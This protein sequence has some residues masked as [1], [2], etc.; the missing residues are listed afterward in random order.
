MARARTPTRALYD[1]MRLEVGAIPGVT[2]VGVGSTMPLRSTQF[3]LDVKAEGRQLATGEAVPHAEGRTAD[4]NYF[5]AAG[6][7][8][9]QGRE[10]ASTDQSGSQLV[11]ILNHTAAQKLF[12]TRNPIGQ[13]IAWTGDVLRFIGVDS[14]WRTVV[15]VVG[16]TKD[17]G[18][19]AEARN[20]VFV[21]FTQE[22]VFFGLAHWGGDP[23]RARHRAARSDSERGDGGRH[24]ERE[25]RT[26]QAQRR[27]GVVVRRAGGDH[28]GGRD[29]RRAC[30]FGELANQ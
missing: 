8:L 28:R 18:L 10:F 11:V 13:R 2:E 15:G 30:L 20:V 4:A 9:L 1:R 23:A 26:A 22:H 14:S 7:P 25:R 5:Q 12:P 16:D 17:G 27:A 21:P 29:R 6:I 24:Q 3:Q 19:D